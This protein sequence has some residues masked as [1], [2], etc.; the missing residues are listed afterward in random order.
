MTLVA[1]KEKILALDAVG[2]ADVAAKQ[3][4]TTDTIFWIASMSKPM[5]TTAFMMLV[6]EGKVSLDDLV[7]K[8]LPEFKDVMV[9]AEKDGGHM[10]LRKPAHPVL[11]RNVLSHTSG[12]VP[13]SPLEPQIDILPLRENVRVYPLVPLHFE[14]GTKYE[15]SNGGINTAGRIIEVISGMKYEDFMQKRLFDPLGMTDTTFWPSEAQMERGAKSY[16]ADKDKTGIEETT[17]NQLTYPLTNRTRAPCPAGGLF[18]TAT[19]CAKFC[20]MLLN[21]GE[22]KGTRL[23][24]AEGVK[25]LTRRQTPA[26]VTQSYGF[27]FSVTPDSFGHGGAYATNMNVDTK[28]GLITVWMVQNSGFPKDWPN[29]QAMFKRW[30]ER[31]FGR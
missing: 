16:K 28:R 31:R 2:A 30:A 27:G 20:Q 7:E 15:Y 4:M 29:A 13:R 1:D 25:Q 24:S 18:S 26:E 8:Y 11:V 12:I 14:P 3:P 22:Y 5:T 10:L 23:L 6:D 19:D 21:G 9:L 17:V